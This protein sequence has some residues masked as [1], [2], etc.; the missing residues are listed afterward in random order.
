MANAPVQLVLNNDRLREERK[1]TPVVSN[2]TDFFGG[3]NSGFAAH[4]EVLIRAAQTIQATLVHRAEFEGLGYVKVTMKSDA[5]AKTHRPQ[6]RIFREH[7]APLVGTEGI[8]EPIFAV[9]PASLEKVIEAMKSAE[10]IVTDRTVAKTGEILPNPSRFRCE[11]SAIAS[12]TLWSESDRREFSAVDAAAWMKRAGKGSGYIITCFP[13][14]SAVGV[15][16]IVIGASKALAALDATVRR[17]NL[18]S[19][20]LAQHRRHGDVLALSVSS[21]ESSD[22]AVESSS[23]VVP[24]THE[25]LLRELESNPLVRSISLPPIVS[26]E[27]GSGTTLNQPA[28]DYYFEYPEEEP[29]TKVG[30]IDGGVGPHLEEWVGARWGQLTDEDRDTGHGTFISGLLIAEKRMNPAFPGEQEHGCI[31]Y[32]IDVLPADPGDTGLPFHGYYPGG[33]TEFFDE[34]EQA[35]AEY[36]REYGVRVFNLSINVRTPRTSQTYGWTAERLDEIALAHDV[37]FVISAGN[38]D[39]SEVRP[40]WHS[41]PTAALAALAA[42]RAGFLAEPGESLRNLSVSAVNPPQLEG[43]VPLALARY[44]RRGPGLRGAT[45]PDFAHIGGSGTPRADGH[46]GLLSVDGDGTMVTGCGTSYATPL[47][48]RRLAD[49]DAL[50]EGD[51]SREVLL[52]LM[53]HFANT[54]TLYSSRVLQPVSQHLIGFGMPIAAERMLQRDDSEITFVIDSIIRPREDNWFEFRW[55]DALVNDGRCSGKARLTLVARPPIAYEH[56]DERVRANIDA[57]LKQRESNGRFGTRLKRVN[58][59]PKSETRHKH[60]RDLLAESMKWQLVK[61]FETPEMRGRGPSADWRFQV[62]YLERAEERLPAAGIPYAAVLTI[63]DP[64]GQAP[65]FNQMRQSLN[66]ANVHTGDL[67]T[68]IRARATT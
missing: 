64:K 59:P 9:T 10:T 66:A 2:G 63:S 12:L 47:V 29:R 42:D 16:S 4:R 48:A 56:G 27:R 58:T 52:A 41:T 31:I 38:L 33:F 37:I 39:A 40:E 53:V 36:R 26:S 49:L 18:V 55:P 60:E 35:V 19:R 32:D 50:I 13:I 30:V 11:V 51:V 8:G 24:E 17:D 65:V 46:Q 25:M 34:I 28:P 44:S 57:H 61:S 54:P 22:E 62:D 15:N 3:N 21:T 7:W 14:I 43:T 23:F 68:S 5:I 1:R 6:K 67:R 20:H 45:K